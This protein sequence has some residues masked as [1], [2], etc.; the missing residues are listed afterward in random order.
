MPDI[1]LK[2]AVPI[3]GEGEAVVPA[4][5]FDINTAMTITTPVDGENGYDAF[6]RAKLHKTIQDAINRP[7][8]N[9]EATFITDTEQRAPRAFESFMVPY[10]EGVVGFFTRPFGY[11]PGFE[12]PFELKKGPTTGAEAEEKAAMQKGQPV[13]FTL[14]QIIGGTAPFIVT[15]PLFPQSLLGT[16]ATFETVGLTSELGRQQTEE[17]LMLS[18]GEKAG[19]YGK[20][21]IKSGLMAPVWYFSGAL[22][23][24]GRPF[25]S[26]MTRA[27]TRGTA[28]VGLEAV[29]GTDLGEALKQGGIITA[30][31]LMFEAPY[32][33]KTALGRGIY[34]RANQI[35]QAKGLPEGR[36]VLDVDKVDAAN[37]RV[38]LFDLIKSFYGLMK[39]KIEKTPGPADP[40]K[41]I[42]Y[43]KL[44]YA[45]EMP[46]PE[47]PGEA[48]GAI[49]APAT[50][51]QPK[52]GGMAVMPQKAPI[53]YSKMAGALA[54]KMP[55]SAPVAQVKGI[56]ASAGIPKEEIEW[57]G[58][59]D[60]MKGKDKIGK[61]EL[62][63]Y[64]SKNQIAVE[65]V[66]KGGSPEK[67]MENYNQ[68]AQSLVDKY[69]VGKNKGFNLNMIVNEAKLTTPEEVEK[70]DELSAQ[71]DIQRKMGIPGKE[72]SGIKIFRLDEEVKL[73]NTRGEIV[74]LP[75]GEEYRTLP[76]LDSDGNTIPNKVRLLDGKQI[77]VFEGELRKLKGKMLQEGEQP[78]AGG[79]A[80]T[81]VLAV[82][83][84][85][86]KVVFDEN[87]KLHSDIIESKEIDPDDVKDVGIINSEGAYSATKA[88]DK[89]GG[90]PSAELPEVP[91][92]ALDKVKGLVSGQKPPKKPPKAPAAQ[93]PEEEP[94]ERQGQRKE[95]MELWNASDITDKLFKSEQEFLERY[96]DEGKTLEEIAGELV[97]DI[98]DIK[99]TEKATYEHIQDVVEQMSAE[100]EKASKAED[101]AM[102]ERIKTYLI[103]KLNPSLKTEGEYADLKHLP[104][105]FAE[106]GERPD[107]F[108]SELG[109]IVGIPLEGEQDVI[110]LVKSYFKNEIQEK[111]VVSE[112]KTAEASKKKIQKEIN[113]ISRFKK[114]SPEH[115]ELIAKV[116]MLAQSKML[117]KI[118]VS[119]IRKYLGIKEMKNVKIPELQKLVDYLNGLKVG[120]KLL[121][122]NQKKILTKMFGEIEGLDLMPK[123]IAIERFGED[124]ELMEGMITS[125]IALELIPTVDIKEG[126]LAI[127]KIVN[128]VNEK[129]D[130]AESEIHRRDDQL[131]V[132]LRKA[133]AARAEKLPAS[134]KIKR[135]LIKQDK[136][137][138][139]ALSGEQVDLTKE[140][141]A[142]VAYLKNFF[143]MAKEK[144][145]LQKYRKNYVT[146]LEQPFM[147][148]VMNV[149]IIGAFQQY[150]KEQAAK[151]G[152]PVDIMLELDNIIGSEKFFRFAL[153]RKGGITPTTNIQKI[154][155]DYSSLFETKVA[156][157][158]I[159]PEGQVVS[160]LLLEGK[161]AVWLKKF[162]QNLKG[163]ALDY[164]FRSGRMGWLARVA[165]AIVD[166]GY[167]KLLA[168]NYYSAI[169]NIV[170][171]EANAIIWQDFS[172]YLR[173]KKRVFSEPKKAYKIAI[174]PGVLEGTYADYSQR[175]IGKLKKM[176]DLAMIGQKAGEIEIRTCMF[177]S[178][179]TDQEW[180][181]GEI[182]PERSRKLRDSIA[183]T[184]GVFSKTDSP[185]WVQTVLG[186]TIMQM[187]RWRI[188]DAMLLRRIVNDA[189]EEWSQDNFKGK[190]TQRLSK[191]LIFYAIGMYAS[192]ELGKAGL[193]K[194][195]QIAQSM[196][197]VVNGLVSLISQG[198]LK[199]MISDNPTLSVIKDFLF[200]AQDIAKHIYVPGAQKPKK[201]E[202]QQGIED[203]Y[204]A[205]VETIKDTLDTLE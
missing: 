64:I 49:W 52:A 70:L 56:L 68:Y 110:D 128:S 198:D 86:G 82:R 2:S 84:K 144:L 157:D 178:E 7:I 19:A 161:S 61:F 3:A 202:I 37:M 58:I 55:E 36:Y 175:G 107:V 90:A 154:I 67:A 100:Q 122:E 134:E 168:L 89:K 81:P 63:D 21:A 147:E 39:T 152:I 48:G 176:Q 130:H 133:Q 136:E 62:L 153:K 142:V 127:E 78:R 83:M 193:K 93:P 5:D 11:R 174:E 30:L 10:T 22:K 24:V 171:G 117:S 1:D 51:T 150:W 115:Q 15:A 169:K 194:A 72:F 43:D 66:V 34:A 126:H 170:A 118:T 76:A 28:T 27:G 44:A 156:L 41:K 104:W 182:S 85:D 162:L 8:S 111:A 196:A 145:A 159:L 20:E 177:T 129:L 184:Q 32:L 200:T 38:G 131:E 101:T 151:E 4:P 50:P 139:M 114:L 204:I 135:G 96:L 181:T 163:R 165:D 91:K 164:E 23:F 172:V 197:E 137:I 31:S 143:A 112:L 53:F 33:A 160:K 132:M 65:E 74:T 166:L 180:E 42:T 98:E 45:P 94:P 103:G 25:L 77:T 105:L 60:F 186:R 109:D 95:Y 116:N 189:R 9:Q 99:A 59:E 155:H 138:F 124:T 6:Q 187:N 173:G 140:E 192:Y 148:K 54:E 183:I 201:I 12:K 26:A 141:E 199:R 57:S 123:R 29:F 106:G 18:T 146:H 158:Q 195:A 79:M 125:H 35:A 92:S 185:L 16:V 120:D 167:I 13:A 121:S 149:G 71:T 113:K 119:R 14:G 108:A 97:E 88:P 75:K 80:H 46:P 102:K 17:S 191:A 179:L 188:T 87:A 69:A 190:G 40:V 47:T 205:P 73:V 203:T